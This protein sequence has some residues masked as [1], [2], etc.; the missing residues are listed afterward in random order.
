MPTL[1]MLPQP[2]PP[3]RQL[4]APP[5][6]SK[7]AAARKPHVRK[8]ARPKTS[9]THEQNQQLFR[10]MA[11]YIYVDKTGLMPLAIYLNPAEL[12][13]V[14][15]CETTLRMS[16][17]EIAQSLCEQVADSNPSR[18]S[19]LLF[20]VLRHMQRASGDHEIR[21]VTEKA[22]NVRSRIIRGFITMY[23]CGR[24]PTK[25]PARYIAAILNSLIASPFCPVKETA[26][27]GAIAVYCAGESK[28]EVSLWLQA[29]FWLHPRRMYEFLVQCSIQVVRTWVEEI[30]SE[31]RTREDFHIL[32]VDEPDMFIL[33]EQLRRMVSYLSDESIKKSGKGPG[34]PRGLAGR[35]DM[36]DEYDDNDGIDK[37]RKRKNSP[38]D[39]KRNIRGASDSV[40]TNDG[41][42]V[43][44]TLFDMLKN[45]EKLQIAGIRVKMLAAVGGIVRNGSAQTSLDVRYHLYRLWTCVARLAE[46]N[47]MLVPSPMVPAENAATWP[48]FSE[49]VVVTDY[50]GPFDIASI[51]PRLRVSKTRVVCNKINHRV[52]DM[53]EQW[54]ASTEGESRMEIPMWL[55]ISRRTDGKYVLGLV[56]SAL[57]TDTPNYGDPNATSLVTNFRKFADEE[58][59]P[60]LDTAIATGGNVNVGNAKMCNQS[61]LDPWPWS[62]AQQ[63]AASGSE[64]MPVKINVGD[65]PIQLMV[66]SAYSDST[67]IIDPWMEPRVMPNS[68]Y[69]LQ[70]QYADM[71]VIKDAPTFDQLLSD[72]DDFSG[73]KATLK[74]VPATPSTNSVWKQQM[75]AMAI[76]ANDFSALNGPIGAFAPHDLANLQDVNSAAHAVALTAY[77]GSD[78]GYDP[79]MYNAVS[80]QPMQPMLDPSGNLLIDPSQQLQVD[81]LNGYADNAWSQNGFDPNSPYPQIFGNS[82]A[83]SEYGPP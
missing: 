41:E 32:S 26:N 76:N 25:N 80:Q 81:M 14:E 24:P 31:R 40:V 42:Q 74:V 83:P 18:C 59:A 82:G 4:E 19:H 54:V 77:Q 35:H 23:E 5:S 70:K 69:N 16:D 61:G 57:D 45:E 65:S 63:N 52:E 48:R 30:P 28:H 51:E 53:I 38:H 17:T 36:Y 43:S 49:F 15:Q 21:V 37:K 72:E 13:H 12:D 78:N 50:S 7:K 46:I 3:Q 27:T 67:N 10:V 22:K 8:P 68:V 62:T 2:Q 60:A 47:Q 1:D 20:N 73:G 75:P 44:L 66:S 34:K 9:W 58:L 6:R 56:I 64:S 71:G 29:M 79:N 39:A 11:E 33:V 55:V